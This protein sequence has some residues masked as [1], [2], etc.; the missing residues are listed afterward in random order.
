MPELSTNIDTFQ[1]ELK[2]PE[3]SKL[4]EDND[5]HKHIKKRIWP[6]KEDVVITGVS[7]RFPEADSLE[8][9]KQNLFEGVDMVTEN[10]RRWPVG[11]LNN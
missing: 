4:T 2:N 10:D 11:K 8:E 1:N 5:T 9:F 3:N 7:G 6:V